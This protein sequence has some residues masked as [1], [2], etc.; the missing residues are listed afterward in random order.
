MAKSV[1]GRLGVGVLG[2]ATVTLGAVETLMT[3]L[4]EISTSSRQKLLDGIIAAAAEHGPFDLEYGKPS[5]RH[6][7]TLDAE[8][9]ISVCRGII[10]HADATVRRTFANRLA[11]AD[12]VEAMPFLGYLA[13]D[14][15]TSVRRSA[16]A[17]VKRHDPPLFQALKTIEELPAAAAGRFASS[18]ASFEVLSLSPDIELDTL[19][20]DS[21]TSRKESSETTRQFTAIK[22]RTSLDY[23]SDR[24]APG[25]GEITLLLRV[26]GAEDAARSLDIR[27][28]AGKEHATLLLHVS[29]QSASLKVE[30]EVQTIRVPRNGDSDEARLRVMA[31]HAINGEGEVAITIFDEFRLVGS[32]AVM[33]RAEVRDGALILE[34]SRDM[35][36]REAGDS[37]AAPYIG[38]TIQLSLTNEAPAR[39]QFHMPALNESG[40]LELVPLGSS[41]DD[42]DAFAVLNALAAASTRIESIEKNLGNPRKVGVASGDQVLELL[43]MDFHGIAREIVDN[44]ISLQTRTV[45]ARLDA[46]AV[47]QW[48]LKSPKLD[49]VPW[50][51]AFQTAA[52]STLKEPILLVRVPVRDDTGAAGS[53]RTAA[54]VAASPQ[55]KRRLVYVVG[56]GVASNATTLNGVLEVVN[57]A[58]N[59]GLDVVPNVTGGAREPMNL[60]KLRDSVPQAD[61]IHFLCHGIVESS[62][63]LYL[64]I[65]NNLGGQ[66]LPHQIRTFALPKQPLVFVNACSS[67]AA[68]FGAAG[69]T[70]FARSFLAAGASAYIGTLAPVVTATA[71]RFATAFFDGLLGKGLSI[72]GAMNAAHADMAGDPDP[73]WRL[74]AVYGDLGVAR[75]SAS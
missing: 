63:S 11:R 10:D 58:R 12:W 17:G 14:T 45:L 38:P 19:P 56:D 47:V 67:A 61:I 33:F 69:F 53:P 64:R 3:C 36:F 25:Q 70:S 62:G 4:P 68:T 18:P 57:V 30:P 32:I 46:N 41:R 51:L 74:Y 27:V 59:K 26:E 50:E 34:K 49:A 75:V 1:F 72:A 52:Q 31:L 22:R 6:Q 37:G 5:N 71:L 66:L 23:A 21:P 24:K 43:A 44:L 73:T 16:Y 48:V 2:D 40:Q 55:T 29:S 7:L 39:I 13:G 8:Q 35:L 20:E 9:V 15:D 42:Y 54:N 28:P 60:L 65:E